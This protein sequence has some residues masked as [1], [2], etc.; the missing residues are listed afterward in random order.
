[1]GSATFVVR[2][3]ELATEPAAGFY[4]QN[5][6]PQLASPDLS[7]LACFHEMY[8]IF[9]LLNDPALLLREHN[10]LLR[11]GLWFSRYNLVFK[12]RSG[13]QGTIWFSRYNLVFKVQSC[14]QGTVL[15]SRYNLV[16]KVQSCFQ[17]TILF[18]RY[19]LVFKVQSYFRGTILF[20][21]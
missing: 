19:N 18:S 16:F 10:L 5:S 6:V 21:R 20:S 14:F 8:K 11:T 9:Q 2:N 13:C 1:M 7:K 15:F 17:G 12:V 3:Y 4:K